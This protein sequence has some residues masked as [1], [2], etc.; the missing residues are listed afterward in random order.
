MLGVS[1]E[2]LATLPPSI[3]PYHPFK[4]RQQRKGNYAFPPSNGTAICAVYFVPNKQ[5]GVKQW[6]GS[7]LICLIPI[8]IKKN[9][10]RFL[11]FWL[12]LSGCL[13]HCV[14]N[15]SVGSQVGIPL[16]C[17]FLIVQDNSDGNNE[18]VLTINQM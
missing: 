14:T 6:T 13:Q 15:A 7:Y 3:L 12:T 10:K 18:S 17:V 9:S 2:F 5:E 16:P 4:N 8:P 1:I 11:H